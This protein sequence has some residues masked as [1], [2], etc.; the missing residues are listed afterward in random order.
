MTVADQI[1]SFYKKLNSPTALPRGVQVMNPFQNKEVFE[2]CK[3]FY[4]QFYNDSQPRKLIMGINPGRL[5]GGMTGIPF[6]DPVKLEKLCGIPNSLQKK[7]ELSADFIYTMIESFGGTQLFYSKFLFSSVCPLGFTKNGI[8]M[9]YYD[10]QSLEKKTREFIIS[11]IQTQLKFSIDRE[12]CFCMGEGQNYKYLLKLNS[13]YSFFN[14]IIPLPHPRFIMQYR[15]K[16]LH[17]FVNMYTQKLKA[18]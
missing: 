15:R 7:S 3:K 8:N 4:Y 13:E 16:K 17:E 12:I 1:L 9:N 6:T 5:G 10:D 18:N 14:K 11:S 2:L